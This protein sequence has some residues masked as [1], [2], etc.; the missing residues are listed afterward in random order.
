MGTVYIKNQEQL[1]KVLQSYIASALEKTQIEIYDVIQESI[2]EYYKEYTPKYYDRTYKFLNSL[3]KPKVEIKGDTIECEVKIDEAYLRYHYPG[4]NFE[5]N[6]PATGR[7]VTNW[8][9]RAVPGAGNHGYTV[10]IGRDVGF[11]DEG[12]QTLGGEIRIIRMLVYNLETRLLMVV[13]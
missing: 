7:D 9:N 10:D 2:S 11:W 13:K 1:G 3:V 4:S 8:A 6:Y 12:I 5:Y